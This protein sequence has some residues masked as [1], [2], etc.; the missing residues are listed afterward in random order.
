VNFQ[1]VAQIHGRVSVRLYLKYSLKNTVAF[2]L[3]KFYAGKRTSDFGPKM[4]MFLHGSIG[5]I[6]QLQILSGHPDP[7]FMRL[8][9]FS[10]GQLE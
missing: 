8:S 4:P 3:V 2:F 9:E 7:I 6:C 5:S 1:V 10:F